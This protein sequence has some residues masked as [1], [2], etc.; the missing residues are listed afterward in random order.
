MKKLNSVVYNKLLLQAGEAKNQDMVKLASGILGAL[1]PVPEEERV[2]YNLE[3]LHDDM[4]QGLWK[5]ATCVIKYYDVQSAD[6]EK[7]HQSLEVMANKLISEVEHS[8]GVKSDQVG[9]LEEK[10][11]GQE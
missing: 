2:H 11:I 3:Q 5:L 7:I 6:A 9:P 1:G 10:L 4:Y 8:I